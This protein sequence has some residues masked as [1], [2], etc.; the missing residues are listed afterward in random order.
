MQNKSLDKILG[1]SLSRIVTFCVT[2]C[3][4]TFPPTGLAESLLI[5]NARG[6]TFDDRG[7]L[8][9]F[10]TLLVTDGKVA[11]L[12][13]AE[14]ARQY[15]RVKA[16][17]LD[18][19]TLL[20]G[21]IDA[22]GHIM[23]LGY[24]LLS[25]DVRD[26]QDADTVAL[27][28]KA[29]AER[30]PGSGWIRGRG[31]NQVLWPGKQFPTA[32]ALDRHLDDRPV[33]L[34]RIDGHAGWANTKALAIAGIDRQTQAPAGGEILRD[35][36][37][38]PTGVLIDNAMALLEAK[39]PPYTRSEMERAL[40]E[41]SG[42]LLRLGIT[43]V[44]DAG[45]DHDTYQLY[46]QQAQTKQLQLRI[47]AMLSARDKHLQ[48]ML[49]NGYI[50]DKDN[51]LSIRSVKI[52]ADGA[53][54][55]RG[56]ALLQPYADRPDTKGL[57]LTPP[58]TLRQLYKAALAARF[59][60]NIHGIGDAGVRLALDEFAY[61]FDKHGG[62]DLRHRVEHAQVVA[63]DD[64]PRFKALDIIPSM[65]PTHATSDKNM[66][67]D[68]LGAERLKGAYAW[69]TFLRQGSP[70][71]AG[72]DFP[73][74]LA[75]PLFGI[76]AAVTRQDRKGQPPGG[77][78]AEQSMSIGQALRAFTRDAAYAAHQETVLGG[79][80]PG[81]WADFVVLDRDIFAIAAADLWPTKV[82][83]TWVAGKPRYDYTETDR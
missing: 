23:G 81:K 39:I 20:P 24:T 43:S 55:S 83:Q 71:A 54:G 7:E 36:Q 75:N 66:A 59:Q 65:Q 15:A 28:V 19:K 34:R 32:A 2:V 4:T 30:N 69:Q 56:A 74:E 44:H 62:R 40:R 72:S 52:Y 76:H 22:H 50:A 68:R 47:Y 46:R 6:Y 58:A 80:T 1:I 5:T 53:L 14:L 82:L 63:L 64:I 12:G 17:D 31:W 67:A 8:R 70:I 27:Q 57:L 11:A 73:V 35:A 13:K 77:W 26:A 48:R 49:S 16:L 29:F 38:N 33:W 51:F 10:S 42:H 45:I 25:L 41:A 37:G 78:L 9:R 3:L 21:L 79:L 60:I 61:A 18:G